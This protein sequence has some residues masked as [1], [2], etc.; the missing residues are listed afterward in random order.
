M[1]ESQKLNQNIDP[2]IVFLNSRLEEKEEDVDLFITINDVNGYYGLEEEKY[3]ELKVLLDEC[4]KL[5]KKYALN[6]LELNYLFCAI[7]WNKGFSHITTQLTEKEEFRTGFL[8]IVNS[9]V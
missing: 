4:S 1:I 8:K 5:P 6:I 9:T 2:F 3:A 7:V